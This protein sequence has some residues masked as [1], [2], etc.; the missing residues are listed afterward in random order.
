MTG[1]NAAENNGLLFDEEGK[2][3]FIGRL[4]YA[5]TSSPEEK[6]QLAKQEVSATIG[7]QEYEQI[8][9]NVLSESDPNIKLAKAFKYYA[10]VKQF[11]NNKKT[12]EDYIQI[13]EALLQV[14]NSVFISNKAIGEFSSR[15]LTGDSEFSISL[16]Q[17]YNSSY[18]DLESSQKH[19]DIL[20]II[21]NNWPNYYDYPLGEFLKRCQELNHEKC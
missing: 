3:T 21:D 5:L 7:K 9:V 20:N 4:W 12:D 10:G 2:L 19:I 8:A 14:A 1:R 15:V 18:K 6:T 16:Q 17:A 11:Y 13:F